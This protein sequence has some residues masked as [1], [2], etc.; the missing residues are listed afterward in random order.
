MIDVQL[1]YRGAKSKRW[2]LAA[3]PAV[4]SYIGPGADGRLWQVDAVV[5]G[6]NGVDVFAVEVSA[7]LATELT[8]AWAAWANPVDNQGVKSR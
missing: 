5:F 1:R 8:T 3:V 7:R 4:G 6:G 2:K